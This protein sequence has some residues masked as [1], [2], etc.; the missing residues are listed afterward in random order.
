MKIAIY[1]ICKNEAAH[2]ER[3]ANS[4]Q[5]ADLRLVCD[6][7]STDNTVSALQSQGVTVIPITV[8]PWRFDSARNTSLN[9]LPADIDVCIYQDLDEVLDAG[10]RQELEK[11]WQDNTTV[12]NHRYRHN[13]NPWQWHSKI[14]ARHNCH[15]VG[16]VHETLSWTIAENPVWCPE[17]YLSEIQDVTK[18]RTSYLNL[19]LKK[20]EEGDCNWR[21]YYFLANDYQTQGQLDKSIEARIKSYEQCD[22]TDQVVKS[23][24]A[25]NIA[26]SYRQSGD[27]S[28]AYRW[29]QVSI[30]DSDERENWY[31]LAEYFYD[32]KDWD[33]CYL[34]AKKCVGVLVRRD[35]FT[36]DP[37]AWG[38][39]AYDYAALAAYNLKL[40]P[41]AIEYGQAAV[42]LAPD[43][44]RLKK[45]LD[46]YQEAIVNG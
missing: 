40:I 16:A 15:W 9:L 39:L 23:Y 36:F 46:F 33:Q 14:H 20:I 17:I 30:S 43:D 27:N 7:G 13:N 11:I 28:Q 32:N 19:L 18:D 38:P 26:K 10:W 12:V 42:Q 4:N 41:N 22:A 34:A 25:R 37:K 8:S 35:G 24:V 31:D 3:W 1:T 29:L 6:T 45:N 2:V 5:E 44:A 21:T